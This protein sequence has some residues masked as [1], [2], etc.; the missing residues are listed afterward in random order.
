MAGHCVGGSGGESR[1]G[2]EGG[3]VV[4]V[5]GRGCVA[6]E[7][8]QDT[9]FIGAVSAVWTRAALVNVSVMTGSWRFV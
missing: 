3:E 5:D 4:R 7:P 6:G 1:D 9:L 2:G 8:Q